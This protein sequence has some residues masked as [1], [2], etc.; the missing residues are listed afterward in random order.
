MQAESLRQKGRTQQRDV[1]YESGLEADLEAAL[2]GADEPIHLSTFSTEVVKRGVRQT[3]LP[4]TFRFHHLRHT[5]LSILAEN[6]LVPAK[7]SLGDQVAA[8]TPEL[9]AIIADAAANAKLTP[10]S[11]KWADVEAKGLLQDFFVKIAG[12]G[13]V[14]SLAEELDTQIESILNG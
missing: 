3:D 7:T 12:G 5:G 8:A 6:G 1:S 11:P 13:D 4:S 2:P 14:A 10:A 9:A